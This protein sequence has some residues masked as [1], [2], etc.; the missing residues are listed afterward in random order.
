MS[1]TIKRKHGINGDYIRSYFVPSDESVFNFTNVIENAKEDVH[2]PV[3]YLLYNVVSS[4]F[5]TGNMDR[6]IGVGINIVIFVFI[7]L[8][9]CKLVKEIFGD[10]SEIWTIVFLIVF[11]FSLGVSGAIQ[12]IRMYLLVAF[13]VTASVYCHFKIIKS[14]TDYISQNLSDYLLLSL[15]VIFGGLTQYYFSIFPFSCILYLAGSS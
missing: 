9:M 3:Y 7:Q 6:S 8:L 10:R 13:F 4:I 15:V 5:S 14:E 12:F 11:G 2:P 1:I